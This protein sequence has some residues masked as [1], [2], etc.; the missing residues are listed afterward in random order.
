MISLLYKID[1]YIETGNLGERT[2]RN[3]RKISASF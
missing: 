2:P 1:F 3:E